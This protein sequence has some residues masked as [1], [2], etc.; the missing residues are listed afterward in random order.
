MADSESISNGLKSE[1][2]LTQDMKDELQRNGIVASLEDYFKRQDNLIAL[3]DGFHNILD[4]IPD[5]IMIDLL[6]EYR[7]ALFRNIDAF[8]SG[9]LGYRH[10]NVQ[11]MRKIARHFYVFDSQSKEFV[12]DERFKDYSSSQLEKM[13]KW[14]KQE[15]LSANI[16][17]SMTVYE[18]DAK[19]RENGLK[20]SIR[21][22][23]DEFRVIKAYS[24][25]DDAT[26]TQIKE[27]LNLR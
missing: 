2:E 25:A 24:I 1:R 12:L 7:H 9:V 8:A 26:K 16:D 23:D 13:S 17:S 22:T 3:N 5:F 27:L 4:F 10:G 11:V 14:S 6:E 21:V 19:V 18:I 20:K 15:L